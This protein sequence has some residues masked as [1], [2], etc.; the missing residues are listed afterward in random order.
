MS[1]ARIGPVRLIATDLDGTLL[2][3][4]GHVSAR[5]T[6][7]LRRAHAAGIVVVAA[8]GRSHRTAA[9][10]L[11]PLG[12]VDWAVCSNGAVLYSLAEDAVVD[13]HPISDAAVQEVFCAVDGKFPDAAFAW[14]H[15]EGFVY[16]ER[17]RAAVRM[18][19][20]A[21]T[22]WP[23]VRP[24]ARASARSLT[25]LMIAH[26]EHSHEQLLALI[27]PLLPA[28]VTGS[29][30]GARF[31][32]VTGEGVDKAFGLARL[33]QRLAIDASEVMAIGDHLNDLAMLQWSG[34]GVAMANAH[35]DLVAISDARAGHHD[36]DGLAEL[37]EQVLDEQAH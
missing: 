5:A 36:E 28:V 11:V 31:V 7:A 24:S 23:T 26:P 8:T 2:G 19:D 21:T 35:P 12:I 25:K 10:R 29:S 6:H 37:V 22:Q 18:L 30:S 1:A 9:P 17:F 15:A 13:H 20:P 3:A 32:E 33:C 27:A 16:E 34:H 14:E 4:D